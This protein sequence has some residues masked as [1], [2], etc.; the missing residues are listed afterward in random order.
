MSLVNN[1][2]RFKSEFQNHLASIYKT[3]SFSRLVL[4]RNPKLCFRYRSSVVKN[5]RKILDLST[6]HYLQD[7]RVNYQRRMEPF[8]TN[9]KSLFRRES[10]TLPARVLKLYQKAIKAFKKVFEATQKSVKIK[11]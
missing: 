5:S 10:L 7:F 2:A 1:Q 3:I 11:I 4:K 8:L 9:R 6:E